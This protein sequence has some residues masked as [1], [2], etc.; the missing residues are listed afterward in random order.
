MPVLKARKCLLGMAPGAILRLTA[1]DPA[2]LIDVRHFCAEAGHE[3]LGAND[4]EGGVTAYF[5]RRG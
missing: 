2:A 4:L 5:I 1:S 3:Y